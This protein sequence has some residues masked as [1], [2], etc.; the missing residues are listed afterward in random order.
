MAAHVLAN[1]Q[2]VARPVQVHGGMG[3]TGAL[4]Q[5]LQGAQGLQHLVDQGHLEA[6]AV[7]Q[8]RQGAHHLIQALAAADAAAGATG[9]GAALLLEAMDAAIG[10]GDMH[11]DALTAGDLL[12]VVD[13]LQA[14]DDPLGQRE[15]DG[16]ILQLGGAA[17]HHGVGDAVVDQRHRGFAGQQHGAVGGDTT[18]LVVDHLAPCAQLVQRGFVL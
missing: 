9:Q 7:G 10:Q 17:H 16:E 2:D 8:S 3:G 5:Q 6:L 18:P 1:G 11:L 4:P 14:V 13:V 15:A 12:D